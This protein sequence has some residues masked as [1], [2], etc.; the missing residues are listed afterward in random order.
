M[1]VRQRD[2]NT[3]IQTKLQHGIS[4]TSLRHGEQ[5]HRIQ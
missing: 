3:S 5:Y 1:F 2:V 4:L